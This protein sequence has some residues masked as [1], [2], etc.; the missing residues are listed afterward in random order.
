MS[1]MVEIVVGI[2]LIRSGLCG[3]DSGEIYFIIFKLIK[4]IFKLLGLGKKKIIYI[5]IYNGNGMVAEVAQREHSNIKCY[6]SAF[7]NI[8]CRPARCAGKIFIYYNEK[9]YFYFKNSNGKA[10]SCSFL[11]NS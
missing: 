9:Y 8:S 5:Y 1:F 4:S 2:N 7:S 3:E 10:K 11:T 6:T